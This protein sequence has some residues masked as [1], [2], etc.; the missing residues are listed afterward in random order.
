MT[1]GPAKQFH[2]PS[3]HLCLAVAESV[4]GKG[5]DACYVLAEDIKFKIDA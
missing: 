5:G 3:G 2:G 4:A 1:G